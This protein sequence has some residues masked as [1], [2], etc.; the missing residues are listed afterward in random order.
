MLPD[1]KVAKEKPQAGPGTRQ[2]CRTASDGL[3]ALKREI[4]TDP[5][6]RNDRRLQA[7]LS[8][9]HSELNKLTQL[10]NANYFWD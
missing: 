10:L 6:L 7:A 4:R 3:W 1:T 2:A 9:V 5:V 8:K